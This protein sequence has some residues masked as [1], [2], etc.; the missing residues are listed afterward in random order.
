QFVGKALDDRVG[1]AAICEVVRRVPT[2]DLGCELSVAAT[3]QEEIGVVGAAGL[4]AREQFD[5]A[6]VVES[7]LSGDVP[8]VGEAAVPLRL[9]GGPA[10]VHKDSLV[11]YDH[12]LTSR[13]EQLA[14]ERGIA[15]Q[16]AVFGSFGSDGSSLMKADV[17]TALLAFP[18][19]YT[20]TPFETGC[21]ADVEAMVELLIA[22]VTSSA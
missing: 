6:I 7:G 20:H 14:A 3:I 17:P 5:A 12:A 19:R 13:L 15:I 21:L 22:Y 8:R 16:H 18:T 1:L 10:L 11:H 2:A 9:G 4:A